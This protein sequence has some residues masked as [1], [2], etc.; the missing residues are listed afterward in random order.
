[1]K[2]AVYGVIPRYAETGI[3]YLEHGGHDHHQRES[4]SYR[5]WLVHDYRCPELVQMTCK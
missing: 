5:N 4:L 1:M 3:V 2:G